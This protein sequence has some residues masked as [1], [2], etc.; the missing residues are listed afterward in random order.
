MKLLRGTTT[1]ANEPQ[2]DNL[3]DDEAGIPRWVYVLGIMAL[4]VIIL[5]AII[6][7]SFGSMGHGM[8]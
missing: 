2:T 7:F 4:L 5:F 1:V 6:H 8:Q 3:G